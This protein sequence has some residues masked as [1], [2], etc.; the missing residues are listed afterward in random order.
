MTKQDPA[1]APQALE[2][3][4]QVPGGRARTL[5]AII[6]SAALVGIT[7]GYAAPLM[8]LMLEA[9]GQSQT[10]VGLN[11][12]MAAVATILLGPVIAKIFQRLGFYRAIMW[13]VFGAALSLAVMAL[14]Q[15]VTV[16]FVFRFLMGAAATV[17]WI[18][19][20]TWIIS[21]TPAQHRGKAIAFYMIAISG[22]FALGAPLILLFGTEGTVPLLVAA[23]LSAL[24]A[25]AIWLARHVVP[26]LPKAPPAAFA[27]AFRIAPLVM[28]AAILAGFT[29]MTAM[30]HLAIY[31]QAAGMAQDLAVLT[32]TVMLLANLVV[33]FPLGFLADRWN[34][35]R[36]LIGCGVIF[37]VV[38]LILAASPVTAWWIWPA[39]VCWG[40]AS[41]GIY[42]LALTI[43]GD[44][45]P[46]EL[47]SSA[48]AAIV[49]IYQL[50]SIVGQ[51]AGGA[52]M[53]L[54][55]HRGLMV[56]LSSAALLF[57]AFAVWRNIKR[58][59]LGLV[60]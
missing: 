29:D 11:A 45:F 42:T 8:A 40:G 30:T 13:A 37:F 54:M 23:G 28:A 59:R 60:E 22:G 25:P 49:A 38:P 36:M 15:E 53:D 2:L 27:Q 1:L 32:L 9:Q 57:L 26:D 7:L 5:I 17:H 56:V 51:P 10:V 12:A 6:A 58:R 3:L 20:E 16:W 47:L 43:L 55:G 4:A 14:W 41:L 48:N 52:G 44:R 31:F 33:Q 39:L 34:R 24:A 19:S 21:I 46:K 50:G 18:G 35:R